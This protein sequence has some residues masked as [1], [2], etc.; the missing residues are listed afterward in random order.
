M[1]YTDTVVHET[2]CFIHLLPSNLS[3]EAT[4]DT[5]FRGYVIPKGTG[6]IPT[7][8]SLLS[9]NQEFPYPEKFKPEHF[10]D[11]NKKFEYS[12]YLK[13][14]STGK[15]VCVGEGLARV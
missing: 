15:Q 2:Q 6:V 12:D 11:E 5:V 13:A 1:P 4:W 7:L 9:D 8:D 3:H 10:L 14:F